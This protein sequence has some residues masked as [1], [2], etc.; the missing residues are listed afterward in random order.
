M[1]VLPFIL[2]EQ[3]RL[4]YTLYILYGL[5]LGGHNKTEKDYSVWKLF[6]IVLTSLR[7]P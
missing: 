5:L 3:I 7:Y 6:I 1:D 4:V 2:S